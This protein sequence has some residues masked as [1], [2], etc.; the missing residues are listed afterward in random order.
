MPHVPADLRLEVPQSNH[1]EA[2][3][4]MSSLA[5]GAAPS[6]FQRGLYMGLWLAADSRQQGTCQDSFCCKHK[7]EQRDTGGRGRDS[8]NF[9]VTDAAALISD[10]LAFDLGLP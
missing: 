3:T 9:Q 8:K 7:P 1:H 4:R 5:K 6:T 2:K 10:H